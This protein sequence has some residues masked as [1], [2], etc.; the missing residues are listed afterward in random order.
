MDKAIA[1]LAAKLGVGVEHLW[2]AL[3]HQGPFWA[4]HDAGIATFA[5]VV[6]L[7]L[8]LATK[9]VWD[10]WLLGDNDN[11]GERVA[12]AGVLAFCATVAGLFAWQSI[13]WCLTAIYNPE[14]YALR[15]LTGHR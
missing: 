4:L 2:Q 14:Y 11:R 3:I 10:G 6:T 7:A 8:G 13:Y 9:R 15:V 1:D 5:F 12:T